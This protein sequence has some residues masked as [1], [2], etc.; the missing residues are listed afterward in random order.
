MTTSGIA[1]RH[2]SSPSLRLMPDTCPCGLPVVYRTW[3]SDLFLCKDHGREWLRS[4]EKTRAKEAIE[5]KDDDALKAAVEP[6]IAR[7][8]KRP[9]FFERIRS[10]VAAF[11]GKRP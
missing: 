1:T 10:A 6:F 3:E 2:L 8:S 5:K 11:V 9:T 4:E 7:I